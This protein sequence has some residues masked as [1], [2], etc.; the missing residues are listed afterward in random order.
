MN[1]HYQAILGYEAV[2]QRKKTPSYKE[3]EPWDQSDI[4]AKYLNICAEIED[5][6]QIN[7]EG[8]IENTSVK[9]LIKNLPTLK[10][11]DDEEEI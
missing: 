4:I 11:E 6:N 8:E 1:D 10:E 5:K 9:D 3:G 7:E 2:Y